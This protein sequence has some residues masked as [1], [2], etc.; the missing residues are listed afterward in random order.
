MLNL[1]RKVLFILLLL[2]YNEASRIRIQGN[3]FSGVSLTG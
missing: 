2:M 3:A 1:R